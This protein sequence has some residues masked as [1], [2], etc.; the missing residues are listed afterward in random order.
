V[1]NLHGLTGPAPG[2]EECSWPICDVPKCPMCK[3]MPD[4]RDYDP[5]YKLTPHELA[6]RDGFPET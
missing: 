4:F 6:Q 3:A 5:A 2:A 1:N